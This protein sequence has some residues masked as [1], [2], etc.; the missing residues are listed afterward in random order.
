MAWMSKSF[1][2]FFPIVGSISEPFDSFRGIW[3]AAF[4]NF[5]PLFMKQSLPIRGYAAGWA[6]HGLI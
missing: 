3:T 2:K 4:P 1:K 6:G 5:H